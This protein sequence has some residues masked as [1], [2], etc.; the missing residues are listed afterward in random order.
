MASAK[1]EMKIPSLLTVER[2]TDE[3]G[4]DAEA[5]GRYARRLAWEFRLV[6][7]SRVEIV[8]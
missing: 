7:V 6:D 3:T 1:T 2:P 8:T 4:R 5:S